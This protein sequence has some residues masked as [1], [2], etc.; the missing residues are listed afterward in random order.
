PV[1]A[2]P[3]HAAVPGTPTKPLLPDTGHP[4]PEHCK[5]PSVSGDAV[6]GVVSLQLPDKRGVLHGDWSVSVD[7]TPRLNAVKCPAEA[8][9]RGL[10]FD[11]PG[12]P[13]GS[14]PEVRETQQ[15]E[16]S[17]PAVSP[18]RERVRVRAF[19]AYQPSFP[20]MKSQS[21]LLESL[22]KHVS[23]TTS[24][25]F[26]LEDQHEVVCIAHER[27]ATTKAWSHFALPPRV[28]YFVQIGVRQ[29]RRD[30]PALRRAGLGVV[31]GA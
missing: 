24:I 3:V 18:A 22:R 27:R 14:A 5:C 19:E 26:V 10:P 8:V 17:R 16:A 23:D 20:G 1:H 15:I 2:F 9:L 21:V 13:L 25:P 12:A 11:H 31:D 30:D 7:T 6:V 4:A 28:Q 29:E